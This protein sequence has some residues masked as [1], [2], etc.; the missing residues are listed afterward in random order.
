MKSIKTL[1]G[2]DVIDQAISDIQRIITNK[3]KAIKSDDDAKE[4]GLYDEK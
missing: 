1:L 4:I 2:I 3:K